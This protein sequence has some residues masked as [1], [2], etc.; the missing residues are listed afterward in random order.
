MLER[1]RSWFSGGS[2]TVGKPAVRGSYDNART[3]KENARNWQTVDYFSAKA[4]NSY[5]VRRILRTR[6][7]HEVSN[8][9]ILFGVVNN[10]ADDLIDSGPTL[11]MSTTNNAFNRKV[12]TL[13]NEWCDEVGL[14]EKLRT[15]KLAK[16]VDGEGILLFKTVDEL[17][18]P[19]KLYPCDVEADQMT[20]PSPQNYA[21]FWV[22]G[23]VLHPITGRPTKYHF[24]RSHPGDFFFP[25]FNPLEVDVVAA[26]H[27]VHWFRKF[28]P[29]QVRGIPVF[30]SSLDLFTELR[31]FRKAVLGSAQI[32][33]SFAA[34]L[35]SEYP[36]SV[37]DPAED[38]PFVRVPI[39]RDAMVMLP[40]GVKMS[41]FDP[42]QPTTTYDSFQ[43]KCVGEGCRPLAY[44]LNLALGTS[45]KF[46]FSSAKLDHIN[47]RGALTCERTECERVALN[48]LFKT[49]YRE[50]VLS[51]AIPAYD[52]LEKIPPHEWHWPGFEPLDPTVDAAADHDRLANGTLT[53]REFWA[54]RGYDWRDV[55][56]QQ[57]LE[58]DGLNKLG[59][60]FGNPASK[61]I[62]EDDATPEGKPS[63]T[64]ENPDDN[65][66]AKAARINQVT[67]TKDANGQEHDDDGKFGKGGGGGSDKSNDKGDSKKTSD[68]H[69][70]TR[71]KWSSEDRETHTAREKENAA[72]ESKRQREDHEV[73]R[74]RDKEDSAREK[75]KDKE[76]ASL[77]KKHEKE[78]ERLSEKQDRRASKADEKLSDKH[79]EQDSEHFD[80]QEQEK[81]KLIE[82]GASEAEVKDIEKKHD[83]ETEELAKKQEAERGKVQHE[84]D[85]KHAEE[86][87]ELE[88]KH[89]AE[90]KALEKKHD[91]EDEERDAKRANEDEERD[92]KRS[93]E[94][95]ERDAKR[96]EEDRKKYHARKKDNPDAHKS[97]YSDED[98]EQH[99]E[100][101]AHAK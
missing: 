47:Y 100:E 25:N 46:N 38:E 41:Q 10:N 66:T 7:R 4:A 71:S 11:Q 97:H 74:T 87:A 94:D 18:S 53:Y 59:L 23:L 56:A 44:P 13:W 67:A 99:S 29:G 49:W 93:E 20:T 31:A 57:K 84:L 95:E 36:P 40:H 51:G 2:S 91:D 5:S 73:E 76:T 22:D 35:E 63:A 86:A 65:E 6:S 92:A 30:T 89:D 79:S 90:R 19:V 45:Q 34:V 52:G 17:E 78:T 88:Q 54:R 33:A 12:E 42:K 50:A 85:K 14:A 24:L 60:Q 62:K 101:P 28:R 39:E 26:S 58:L 1:V 27:V 70:E 21:E 43:E 32:A 8:N 37:T 83:T 61:T 72:T 64:G 75:V 82:K 55:L 81:E 77:E 16:E 69:K 68:E 48:P 96:S 15:V 9:P 80:R 98:H 3:T